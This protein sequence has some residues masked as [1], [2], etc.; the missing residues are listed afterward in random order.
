MVLDIPLKSEPKVSMTAPLEGPN[1]LAA[2][3]S[4]GWHRSRSRSPRVSVSSRIDVGSSRNEG[5]NYKLARTYSETETNNFDADTGHRLYD[6]GKIRT[7][8]SRT[9]SPMRVGFDSRSSSRKASSARLY[10]RSHTTLANPDTAGLTGIEDEYIPGLNF[11]D[12]ILDWNRPL[13]DH[14]AGNS[15]EVSYLDLKQL[16]AKVSPQPIQSR[17]QT[18]PKK[19]F[20]LVSEPDT[21]ADPIKKKFKGSSDSSGQVSFEAVLASLPSNFND[22]PYSQRKKMVKEFSDSIDYPQFSQFAKS[23]MSNSL[24]SGG[25]SLAS[26]P[27][28]IARNG[29]FI[30]QSRRNSANTVAGRLLALSS[31]VDL[32]KLD[33]TPKKNVDEKGAY[34]LNHQL[35]KVIGF[36]AWGIIRECTSKTGV[37]RAV[38]I[39]KS[40][41]VS[42]SSEK[43]HNP[44]VLQIFRKEIDIWK[45]LQ[46]PNILPLIDSVETD[47]MIFCL[48]N[49]VNG[50]TLFDL[51]SRWG[52][53]DEGIDSTGGPI[54]Y[55]VESQRSRLSTTIK[56]AQQ[57]VE[58]I[59][60]M[61]HELGIVHG[62][63]KLENVLMDDVDS[64]SMKVIVCDFGMSRVYNH[65]LSR[66][67][68]GDSSS[69]ASRSKSSF[70]SIRR[71]YD[72]PETVNSKSLFSDD[73]KLGISQ[74]FRQSGICSVS[75]SASQSDASLTSFHEFKS[76]DRS[77]HN[78]MDTGLPHSHIGSL[79]YASPELLSPSPP[80]L[81]PSA[82]VWALGVLLYTM[83]VGR[84]P[85]QHPYEP[86]LRAMITAGK[87]NR[88]ELRQSTLVKSVIEDIS[89]CSSSLIDATRKSELERVEKGW[90]AHDSTEFEWLNE[91]VESCLERDITKRWDLSTV[92]SALDLHG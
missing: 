89:D 59:S 62:D 82:D 85:F 36:G 46:H 27:T 38:K 48:T 29:S 63:L 9:S 21:D 3:S 66:T 20:N 1:L 12:V 61:H 58:A 40:T 73:S 90:L 2:G 5:S 16:H 92:S 83:T 65:R 28:S 52:H 31:S 72:G 13:L 81:G 34:V 54:K 11:S 77:P 14:S 79:P 18:F 10:T 87:I 50:G 80:P 69:Y 26:D 84:L 23:F 60:Y 37:V 25:R 24:G 64:E 76:R 7:R 33:A 47:H 43:L 91:L 44:K 71:P 78:E 35:G 6:D 32:K 30:R 70:A 4:S 74:L 45:Q 39:V 22:L 55:N 15:R 41:K 56:S 49:R 86:R 68:S 42:E 8:P 67:S 75:L 53:F 57:I 88:N 51:V 19:I 17:S